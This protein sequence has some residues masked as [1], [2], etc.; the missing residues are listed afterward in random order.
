L[1]IDRISGRQL[2]REEIDQ[3]WAIDRSEVIHHVYYCKSGTLVLKPEYYEVDGWPPGEAEKYTPL[4]IDCFAR[5]GWF[6]GLFDDAKLIGAAILDGRFIGRKQDQLQLTFLHVS[7]A[8]RQQGLGKRLFTL[9]K[10]KARERGAKR[11]YIS[12]TP[13][14]NTID[15]YR[16]LGCVVTQEVEAELFAL[17][18]K[19]IHLECE[20]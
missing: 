7:K 6:Y 18:P 5:S 8:Y 12:A 16:R 14:E 2:R 11:L 9:A 13:S 10:A 4:L 17:E 19:D 1:E 20:V 3:V 15:F